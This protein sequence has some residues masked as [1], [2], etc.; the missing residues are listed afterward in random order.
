MKNNLITKLAR[1]LP[2][3][4]A[5]VL[6][7]ASCV[8]TR[9]TT[10]A[11][12]TTLVHDTV[13]VHDTTDHFLKTTDTVYKHDTVI[14]IQGAATRQKLTRAQLQ[15]AVLPGG[16]K[17]PQTYTADN[18]NLHGAIN[19]DTA[20][21]VDF[22]CKEDSL[23]LVIQNLRTRNSTLTDSLRH[24]SRSTTD[25]NTLTAVSL[26]ERVTK[27]RLPWYI[28]VIIGLFVLGEIVVRLVKIY[29]KSKIP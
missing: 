28:Y 23:T 19:I 22:D 7:F 21:N 25:K 15:P 2:V 27:T 12:S 26:Y 13:T 4:G 6:L 5:S 24:N 1:L 8:T 17:V 14:G 16:Q 11:S 9:H 20:G 10:T 3:L 18:G 29:S